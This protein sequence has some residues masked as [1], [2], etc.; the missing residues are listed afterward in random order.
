[1]KKLNQIKDWRS[2]FLIP[3]ST[4]IISA[5]LLPSWLWHLTKS[6]LSSFFVTLQE[7]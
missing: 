7:I 4:V 1:M 3:D 6:S 2:K 5:A